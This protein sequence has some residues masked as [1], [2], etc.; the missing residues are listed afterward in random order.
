LNEQLASTLTK[1]L[2]SERWDDDEEEGAPAEPIKPSDAE[3]LFS[4]SGPVKDKPKE[5]PKPA[6]PKPKASKAKGKASKSTAKSVPP[7][8]STTTKSTPPPDPI[9]EKLRQ[10]K[11][12]QSSDIENTK[13]LFGVVGDV[14]PSKATPLEDYDPKTE[15]E[16][17]HFA[18]VLGTKIKQFEVCLSF[19]LFVASNFGL[20][21]D[22]FKEKRTLSKVCQNSLKRDHK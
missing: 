12:V 8:P 5:K 20:T 1:P 7:Q 4:S 6:A 2:V 14:E 22:F 18:N 19:F 10:Q 11:L 17:D 9:Q 16:F 3:D 13:D 21:F 15:A